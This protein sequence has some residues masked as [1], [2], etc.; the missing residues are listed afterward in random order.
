[1]K[2]HSPDGNL[3]ESSTLK[4]ENKMT[5]EEIKFIKELLEYTMECSDEIQLDI[6]DCEIVEKFLRNLWKIKAYDKIIEKN[7]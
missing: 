3:A 1:L 4:G 2:T 7:T 5:K 6:D